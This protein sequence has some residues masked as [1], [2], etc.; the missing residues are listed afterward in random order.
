MRKHISVHELDFIRIGLELIIDIGQSKGFCGCS[1]L[2]LGSR[3]TIM[4]FSFP[5]KKKKESNRNLIIASY[6]Y[7]A[8]GID[9]RP[10]R[11]VPKKKPDRYDE[12]EQ[13]KRP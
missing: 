13:N 4:I 6:E 1:L 7:H 5:P 2:H 10:G 3:F 12:H 8:K 9:P 11:Q